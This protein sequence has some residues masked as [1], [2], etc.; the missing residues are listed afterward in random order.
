M[1]MIGVT[2]INNVL[3]FNL[4]VGKKTSA[5]KL[6]LSRLDDSK[7][8]PLVDSGACTGIGR[9]FLSSIYSTITT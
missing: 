2:A 8:T 6:G 3:R 4:F 9:L 7:E 1:T 5:G